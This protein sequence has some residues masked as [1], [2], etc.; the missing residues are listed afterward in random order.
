MFAPSS[1]IGIIAAS[2]HK[3]CKSLPEY[4]SVS[5]TSLSRSPLGKENAW[6]LSLCLKR[7]LLT[8]LFGRGTYILFT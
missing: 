1:L 8:S 3:A 5:L 2:S 7:S 6:P 4:P